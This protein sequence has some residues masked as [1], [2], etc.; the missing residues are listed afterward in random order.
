MDMEA[1]ERLEPDNKTLKW[2]YDTMCRNI[3]RKRQKA[4]R[5]SQQQAR[6]LAAPAAPQVPTTTDGYQ[7]SAA[8]KHK[9]K[10]E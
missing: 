10:N 7:M 4:T 1:Y 9:A 5:Q 3:N 8:D 2:L 6:R